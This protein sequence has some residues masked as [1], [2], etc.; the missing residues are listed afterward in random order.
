MLRNQ[1]RLLAEELETLKVQKVD[2]RSSLAAT[3]EEIHQT[4]SKFERLIG[5]LEN[6]IAA[7]DELKTVAEKAAEQET[8]KSAEL[9]NLIPRVAEIV[10]HKVQTTNEMQMKAAVRY[11]GHEVTPAPK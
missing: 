7:T 3:T 8:Q 1:S 2:L 5:T 10:R 11:C 6:K 9:M 4:S